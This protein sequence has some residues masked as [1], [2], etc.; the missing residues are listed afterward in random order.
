LVYGGDASA[1]RKFGNS[2]KL[3]MAI[4]IADVN[5]AKA[6]TMAQQAVADGVFTS[7]ADDFT[8]VFSATP[9]NTNPLWED[10]VES[11]RA[12]FVAAETLADLMN[13]LNDPRRGQF[14]SA[15]DSVG[16]VIGAPTGAVNTYSQFSHP[17]DQLLDPTFPGTILGYT[18]VEFLLAD[19]VERGYSV[20]GT[21]A[22]HYEAGIRNSIM[23][24]G[25]ADADT[26]YAQADV[27]YATAPGTWKQ[28][29]ALQKYIAMYN[30]GLEAW[31][32]YRMYDWPE[33]N[34][35]IDAGTTPPHRWNYPS[36]EFSINTA[37]VNDAVARKGA[38]ID[39]VWTRIF[40]DKEP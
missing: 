11:G 35:A 37:S 16:G 28:K 24:W 36:S 31:T 4:R 10:L 39:D 23:E 5:D 34:I 6:S 12:D 13:P 29:I 33:M 8:L 22:E 3:R 2:L 7:S 18:E 25:A 27:D 17:G 15:L 30:Q 26:Y 1:W 40:W 20:G 21:A 14:F 38:G 32:T 9:P 19:A